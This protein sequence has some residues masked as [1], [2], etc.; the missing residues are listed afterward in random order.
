M[1]SRQRHTPC[2][3]TRR[4]GF[5]SPEHE[6]AHVQRVAAAHVPE[7]MQRRAVDGA[8]KAAVNQVAELVFGERLELDALER[9]V[10]PEAEDGV[11]GRL[12]APHGDDHEAGAGL[13]EVAHQ[14][15]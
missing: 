2:T 1:G 7:P 15:G 13:G 4:A 14:G 10:L 5:D 6:L 11:G 8:G 3:S 9:S 12:G